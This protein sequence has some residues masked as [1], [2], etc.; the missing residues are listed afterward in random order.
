MVAIT[1]GQEYFTN[2][3]L[4]LKFGTTKAVV[5][6]W[7]DYV[8]YGSN[9]V[10]EGTVAF[11]VANLTSGTTDIVSDVVFV[12]NPAN[13]SIFIEKIEGVCETALVGGTSFKLGLIEQ[14]DR[15]TIPSG[16]DHAFI[17]GDVT[18][19]YATVG[20]VN[21]YYSTTSTYA[22]SLL[23]TGPAYSTTPYYITCT[24]SGTFTAGQIR[25]RIYYH[26]L[27]LTIT[28]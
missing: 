6:P 3:G 22:G 9:R 7:G 28:Q 23:G 8:N 16:Y 20:A 25:F 24:P 4:L 14:K 11:T 2:S 12:G 13:S 19:S 27:D 26:S 18:A 15:A 21:S 5:S 10:I 1:T 17:N